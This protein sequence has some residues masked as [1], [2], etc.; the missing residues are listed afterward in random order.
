MTRRWNG[1]V[2]GALAVMG[3]GF[4]ACGDEPTGMTSTTLPP[5]TGFPPPGSSS[6]D[7]DTTA[8]VLDVGAGES[9]MA[10]DDGGGCTPQPT[11]AVL[12]GTVYAP[13][14]QIPISGAV[15]YV[16]SGD[17]DPVPDGVYC[18]ECV[19]ITCNEHFVLTNAD[20]TFDLPAIAGTGRKLV[21]QKG[22]FLHIT[23][24]DVAEGDNTIAPNQSNL[25]GAWNPGAGE[26]VPR[27]AVVR[28]EVYDSIYNLLGKIGMG[29]VDGSGALV[30]GTENFDLLEQP[31]GGALLDDLD[32][33]RQYHIIFVPCMSQVSMGGLNQ[34]RIDNIRQWVSEGGKWYVTDWANEYLYQ[35][36]PTYQTLHGQAINP[37]LGYYDTTGLVQDSE[38]LAWLQAL[39]APLKDVGGGYPNLLSLP[40]VELIDNWSGVDAIPP[41]IVQDEDGMDVDVG[42][43]TWVEGACPVCSPS[44]QL[45]PMTISAQ[46]GCGRLMFSTYH[47]AEGAHPGLIPQELILLYIILEIGVCHDETPPPPPPVG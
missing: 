1:W 18:A 13:N 25:P 31:E 17:P 40:T 26:Y 24:I 14:L 35:V 9:G 8:S 45:R 10:E 34:Q 41:I 23:D 20:G 5:T 2:L 33:M 46:Y 11:N 44:N 21:V 7:G 12:H 15:V 39:P 6:L 19:Q 28:S 22:Q 4:G 32:A 27:I 3:F 30:E 36:F 16:T 29:Q 47:T 37:D 43:H 38:M 42:H